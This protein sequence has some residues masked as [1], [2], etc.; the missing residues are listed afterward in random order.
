MFDLSTIPPE[1]LDLILNF[2]I[3]SLDEKE[4]LKAYSIFALICKNWSGVARRKILKVIRIRGGNKVRELIAGFS[5]NG[6][7]SVVRSL[8]VVFI[9][10]IFYGI[11]EIPSKV[12]IVEEDM[13]TLDDFIDLVKLLPQLTSLRLIRP[14]FT[15]LLPQHLL[16]L[17][18]FPQITSLH[19]TLQHYVARPQLLEAFAVI[20]P[21]IDR[22]VLD[23][24]STIIFNP[25]L[26]FPRLR[27]LELLKYGIQQQVMKSNN[28]LPFSSI[29]GLQVVKLQGIKRKEEDN[30]YM[31]D[32]LSIKFFNVL[33]STIT[34]LKYTTCIDST[35]AMSIFKHFPHLQVADLELG[36]NMFDRQA[37]T[38]PENFF[39]IIPVSLKVIKNFPL[40]ESH[41]KYLQANPRPALQIETIGFSFTIFRDMAATISHLPSSVLS[42]D[43]STAESGE[44]T[45]LGIL[46]VLKG[47][48]QFPCSLSTIIYQRNGYG[49]G[50]DTIAGFQKLGITLTY[51]F[52]YD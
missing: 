8:E 25:V 46:Q 21:N 31:F 30:L 5:K 3:K 17:S 50:P 33:S 36:R 9:R 41:F 24:S 44:T 18:L 43:I 47:S 29:A 34:T 23:G 6:M 10:E 15:S 42:I 1:V 35:A 28:V 20:A 40:D 27:S 14:T 11:A 26:F 22:L 19:L 38:L 4:G 51:N 13:V 2:S 49:A 45:I 7:G 39:S 16:D 37:L 12:K 32:Q 48:A 52:E